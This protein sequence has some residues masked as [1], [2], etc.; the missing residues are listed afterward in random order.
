MSSDCNY[1]S[2]EDIETS[3]KNDNVESYHE[4]GNFKD[5]NNEWR[6]SCATMENADSV[7]VK[8]NELLRN[9]KRFFKYLKDTVEFFINPKHEFDS[10]VVELFST[11]EYLGGRKTLNFI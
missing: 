7:L 10:E 1:A 4:K 8:L 2:E 11:I 5:A 6:I 9:K 3:S